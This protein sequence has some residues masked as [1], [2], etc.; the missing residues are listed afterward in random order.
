M[1]EVTLSQEEKT[2]LGAE[3]AGDYFRQIVDFIGFTPSDAAVIRD[4]GLVIEKHIP[5]IVAD[6][7]THLLHYPPTRKFFLKKDDSLDLEYIQKRMH[8]LTNFWRRTASGI[9]DN[10]YARYVDYVGQAHTSHGADPNIYIAERYVIGQVGFMQRAISR[11][12]YE[13]L[14]SV[15][16]EMERRLSHAWNL[17]MMAILEMLARPYG[18]EEPV[19][20][21]KKLF[22]VDAEPVRQL[23]IET[24]ERGLG[25]YQSRTYKEVLV[26]QADEIPDGQ[27]KIVQ[28]EGRSIGV[29]HHKGE[30]VAL[31]NYCLHAGGPVASG[32]LEGDE[33]VCP[34][35]GFRYCLTN[36]ELLVDPALKLE[37]YEVI[38]KDNAVF[39]NLP[40]AGDF[41]PLA[42]PTPQAPREES[43]R[44]KA[45][46]F[47]VERL[48]PGG[49][50]VVSL[51]GE[52]VVVFN[53]DGEYYAIGDE[54]THE[55][56]PLSE[57]EVNGEMVICPWHG[58]CFDIRSGEVKCG[59]ADEPV[60]SFKVIIEGN[61]GRVE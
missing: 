39:L 32:K 27:R 44:L 1:E 45:N 24:Y 58:S 29:F 52:A 12:I 56:G 16:P 41:N 42:S 38:V 9:Y 54:C 35:H 40:E 55:G 11:A 6:F 60:K 22:S 48:Q 14:Q 36:G 26:A 13:E 21:E 33:L 28:I 19:E 43:V 25:L 17:L 47:Q 4:N 34:W 49:T 3:N 46:E 8:H 7:Y 5:S 2:R 50:L 57:G 15:D 23:A 37:K 51:N 30:W 10:D 20:M 31:R 18:T 61:V 53:L 59:P